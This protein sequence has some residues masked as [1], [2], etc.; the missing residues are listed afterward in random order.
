MNFD[1]K[2]YKYHIASVFLLALSLTIYFNPKLNTYLLARAQKDKRTVL[3]KIITQKLN[4][5]SQ[6]TLLKIKN[7]DQIWLE[8]YEESETQDIELISKLSL[9][10]SFDAHIFLKDKA[11]NLAIANIDR[12]SELEIISPTYNRKMEPILNVFKYDRVMEEFKKVNTNK[13]KPLL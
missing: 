4:P 11:T 12:D 10:G 6:F 8:V 13:N 3:A 5:H 2:K 1:F 7:K 9:E